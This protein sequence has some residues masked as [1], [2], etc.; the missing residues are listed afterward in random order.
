MLVLIGLFISLLKKSR[1]IKKSETL[2]NLLTFV[3]KI[4][5]AG[6]LVFMPFFVRNLCFTIVYSENN[7]SIAGLILKLLDLCLLWAVAQSIIGLFL[8]LQGIELG[9]LERFLSKIDMK[10]ISQNAKHEVIDTERGNLNSI[11]TPKH[12]HNRK[13]FSQIIVES[14]SE[15]NSVGSSSRS[16]FSSSENS[17]NY[18]HRS[19][20]SSPELK[21]PQRKKAI[22]GQIALKNTTASKKN[23]IEL[24]KL[25]SERSIPKFSTRNRKSIPNLRKAIV[26]RRKSLIKNRRVTSFPKTAPMIQRKRFKTLNKLIENRE[27]KI[28]AKNIQ[29]KKKLLKLKEI[30]QNPNQIEKTLDRFHL[31]IF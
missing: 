24:I 8:S 11:E 5:S 20:M 9:K 2:T 30:A 22:K 16:S 19:N 7:S 21:S 31:A 25:S 18:S 1:S 4:K 12:S 15:N 13:R 23:K 17:S 28:V 27:F 26:S 6:L 14:S 10:L 29:N 3:L